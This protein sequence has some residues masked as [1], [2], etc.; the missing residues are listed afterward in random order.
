MIYIPPLAFCFFKLPKLKAVKYLIL[1]FLPLILWEFFSLIY[2]GFLFPN[3]AYAKLNTGIDKL[4]LISRG[5][6]YLLDSLKRDPLT[7]GTI[8]FSL[9]VLLSSRKSK[10]F[11]KYL[12]VLCGILLYIF[13]VIKIGGCF[14]SG[15][16]FSVPFFVSIMLISNYERK[17]S[18]KH[19]SILGTV[20]FVLVLVSAWPPFL[21]NSNYGLL[22]EHKDMGKR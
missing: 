5:F 6:A 9:Y 4:E 1:G 2:Y 20:W 10:D 21:R 22:P 16:F 3:T 11:I 19:I 13:Y 8:I 7:L 14:M 18:L 17:L 15:R 12:S